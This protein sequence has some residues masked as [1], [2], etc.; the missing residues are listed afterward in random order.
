MTRKNVK[1]SIFI[2]NVFLRKMTVSKVSVSMQ[3]C[4]RSAWKFLLE[5]FPGIEDRQLL[6]GVRLSGN[7]ESMSRT[8][9]Q[10]GET[11]THMPC[12]LMPVCMHK[13]CFQ[14]QAANPLQHSGNF[15]LKAFTALVAIT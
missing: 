5:H 14:N 11:P 8:A 4:T 9:H 12:L 7:W 15:Y 3:R 10:P 1:E 2:F 6:V 13:M